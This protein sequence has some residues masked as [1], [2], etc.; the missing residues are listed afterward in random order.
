[1]F[2]KLKKSK[3]YIIIISITKFSENN[4]LSIISNIKYLI[5]H[6]QLAYKIHWTFPIY[7]FEILREHEELNTWLFERFKTNKDIY[8]PGTYSGSPHE[9]MLHDEIHLDLYWALK[10]TI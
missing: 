5:E 10:N 1:M 2:R 3:T 8:M 9:Y 4:L 7:F 6:K